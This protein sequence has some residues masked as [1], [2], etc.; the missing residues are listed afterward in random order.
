MRLAAALL[1][2]LALAACGRRGD[3]T[4]PGPSSAVIYPHTYPAQ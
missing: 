3:P 1:C 2:L 4:P